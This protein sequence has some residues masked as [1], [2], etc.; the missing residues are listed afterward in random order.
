MTLLSRIGLGTVQFGQ[1]YG[2]SNRRGKIPSDEAFE[3]LKLAHENKV[4]LLDTAS[5]Y[6]DAER[7]LGEFFK[8]HSLAF[9]VVTK[10][11]LTDS[12]QKGMV[13]QAY[14]QSLKQL[15]ISRAYGY[16]IHRFNDYVADPKIWEEMLELKKQ[17]LVDKVGF[18]IY[19]P[20]ELEI[21]W[22]HNVEMDL[23][24]LPY[25]IFDRRFEKYFPELK[26]RHVEIH[27]RSVFLQGLAF[28][29]ADTLPRH[30]KDAAGQLTQIQNMAVNCQASISAVC[31]NFVLLNPRIDQVILGIDSLSHF[32]EDLKATE[33]FSR[34]QTVIE[35]LQNLSIENEE[36]LLPYKWQK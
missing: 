18:S 29:E 36:V 17:G 11:V 30:L 7:V 12:Y 32:Q 8:K 33:S 31:L 28:M 4:N 21:L 2:V 6:G 25:S 23:I 34:V 9:R 24:Q 20:R 35:Q 13:H 1:D 15:N 22:Q 14:H 27:A 26:Q 19:T 5:S 3:V 10:L 16:L